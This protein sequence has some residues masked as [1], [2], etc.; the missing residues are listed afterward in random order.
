MRTG[1]A[2]LARLTA[3]RSGA[4]CNDDQFTL[5]STISPSRADSAS[6]SSGS[7]RAIDAVCGHHAPSRSSPSAT[8]KVSLT[9]LARRRPRTARLMVPRSIRLR[10]AER[11]SLGSAWAI[12]SFSRLTRHTSAGSANEPIAVGHVRS[13]S[14]PRIT[15][16]TKTFSIDATPARATDASAKVSPD[17]PVLPSVRMFFVHPF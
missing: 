3:S 5:I 2:I 11:I 4:P 8:A 7:S 9:G 17:R 16:A 15:M 6:I 1:S 14:R 13:R 10:R 12:P